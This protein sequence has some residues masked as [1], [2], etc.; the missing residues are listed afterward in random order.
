MLEKLTTPVSVFMT[1]ENEEGKNR[2]LNFE[3]T[4]NEHEYNE[5]KKWMGKFEIEI[6]EASEPTDII[7]ENRHFTPAD[8]NKKKIIVWSIL[9]LML[10]LSFLLILICSKISAKQAGTYPNVN[11]K[12]LELYTTGNDL[13]NQAFFEFRLNTDLEK[14]GKDVRYRGYV[15]CFC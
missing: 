3:E 1:F 9:S 4:T 5:I 10:S 2:A 11:C 14:L 7:W 6:Q 15:Q 8:R 12:N 13:Q